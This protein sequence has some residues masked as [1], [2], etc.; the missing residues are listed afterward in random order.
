MKLL[1]DNKFSKTKTCFFYLLIGVVLLFSSS[2]NSQNENEKITLRYF[3]ENAY[4]SDNLEMDSIYK[5]MKVYKELEGNIALDKHLKYWFSIYSKRV[6]DDFEDINFLNYNEVLRLDS[7][8]NKPSFK[9]LVYKNKSQVYYMTNKEQDRLM[10][11]FILKK[12]KVIAFMPAINISGNDDVYPLLL[13][14]KITV[15]Y[16]LKVNEYI[17]L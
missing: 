7:L 17:G 5:Y 12:G 3:V 2:M 16:I 14:K 15:D 11:P 4:Y 1:M 13:N 10:G 9:N 8:N 6:V